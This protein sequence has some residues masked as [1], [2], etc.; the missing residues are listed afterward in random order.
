MVCINEFSE[1]LFY[2][3]GSPDTYFE[4]LSVNLCNF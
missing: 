1:R 4:Y 2:A 3:E